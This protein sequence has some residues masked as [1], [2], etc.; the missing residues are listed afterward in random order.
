MRYKLLLSFKLSTPHAAGARNPLVRPF[1]SGRSRELGERDLM[2]FRAY[3]PTL[4]FLLASVACSS[5]TKTS[6]SS[7]VRDSAGVTIVESYQAS[8]AEGEGWYLSEEP[9]VTIGTA[10][11]P[12]EYS[13]YSVRAALL[14]P[15]RRLLIA[16]GGSDELRYFD[17]SG[18]HLYSVGRD[19]F[20]PGEFKNIGG[21]WPVK[22]SLVIDDWGQDRV[23]V[24]SASG[25][26]GRTLML[27][28][29]SALSRSTAEGVF[30]DGSM[31]GMQFVFQ[32]APEG[33]SLARIDKVYRRFS[34]D[35]E[36][37]DSLG[38]FFADDVSI[39][40]SPDDGTG[41][42]R[43]VSGDA[44]F[45]RDASTNIFG[46]RVY[47][48]S[49]ETYE[50][51]IFDSAGALERIIRRPVPNRPVTAG[52]IEAFKEYF[53]DE[54]DPRFAAWARRHV[55][56]L[57]FPETMPAYGSVKVDALGNVWVAEYSLGRGDRS[58][59]WTVFDTDGRMLGVVEVPRG[60]RITDI[61]EDYL[62]GSWRTDLDVAQVKMYRL[63]RN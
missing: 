42:G 22:D 50:I 31:L 43:S 20:G 26:Y 34:P 59:N 37:L 6:K 44:A 48:A 46:Q 14:L 49:S 16:N 33:F 29:E 7:V 35:G 55:D 56:D 60:G 36:V 12:E 9:L 54:D 11:G 58:G 28:R 17:S 23:L 10:D 62:I 2:K 32:L 3:I 24:F 13:L 4:F 30:P 18:T 38:V 1:G 52:D 21:V 5:S 15:D 45:G 39:D 61:G 57:E 51:Q 53:I 63:F 27:E 47:Y 19:G 8:W 41:V 25:E 40:R